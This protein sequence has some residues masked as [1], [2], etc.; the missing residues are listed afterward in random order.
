[1]DQLHKR[2]TAEQVKA[3]LIGISNLVAERSPPP[4]DKCS[5]ER[6]QPLVFCQPVLVCQAEGWV[7]VCSQ[8]CVGN[9]SIAP[10]VHTH[11]KIKNVPGIFAFE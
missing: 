8:S 9:H 7:A 6:T 4:Q 10:T 5:P 3:L 11:D 2:F 1:M